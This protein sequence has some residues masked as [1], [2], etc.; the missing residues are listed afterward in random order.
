MI[1]IPFIIIFTL[2]GYFQNKFIRKHS[3]VIYIVFVLLSICAFIMKNKIP[4]TEPFVQGYLGLSFFYIVMFIGALNKSN[5]IRIKLFSIRKEY[6]IIGFILLTP[7]ALKYIIEFLNNVRNIQW[8]GLIAFIVMIP[9]FITSFTIIRKTFKY[10]T[11]KN[12]QR[13]AYLIYI[14]IFIHLIMVAEIPNLFIY[15]IIFIPY[16]VLKIKKEISLQ[17]VKKES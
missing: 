2:L 9:L 17:L 11:W 10:T 12:I 3:T 7:H 13:W 1:V 8:F 16:I 4:L 14:L 15:I 5:K 6:S